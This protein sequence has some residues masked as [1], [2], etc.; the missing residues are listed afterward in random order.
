MPSIRKREA[1]RNNAKRSTGPRSVQGKLIAKR[2]ALRHGLAAQPAISLQSERMARAICGMGASRLQYEDALNIAESHF[3]VQAV[4]IARIAAIKRV[5][6]VTRTLKQ[7]V[8]DSF[9]LPPERAAQTTSEEQSS[10]EIEDDLNAFEQALAE[11][12]RYDRYERRALSR[13]KQA[14]RRFVATFILGVRPLI[15]SDELIVRAACAPCE[16]TNP[17]STGTTPN[18]SHAGRR[19][20]YHREHQSDSYNLGERFGRTNPKRRI[21]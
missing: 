20:I 14:I 4:R 16:F 11:M 15:G 21:G 2:N 18:D 5:T 1:N 9:E 8:A 17:S 10:P 3:L 13:R 7:H 6:T 19:N 12:N